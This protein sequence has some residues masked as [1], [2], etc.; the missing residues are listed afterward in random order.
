MSQIFKF[1]T[2]TTPI[3]MYEL[4]D[5]IFVQDPIAVNQVLAYNAVTNTV[6]LTSTFGA[7][8][9]V[10]TFGPTAITTD[11][12]SY[13][14][15]KSVVFTSL[16]GQVIND[17][18][19]NETDNGVPGDQDGDG[20]NDDSLQG[21]T[22]K[23]VISGGAGDDHIAGLGNADI[24]HGGSGDDVLLG[25]AGGDVLDG[26]AG[27][28]GL[29]GDTGNDILDGGSGND[30]L[31]GGDGSDKLFG[32]DGNDDLIGGA[33]GDM[34]DGGAGNDDLYGNLGDDKLIGGAGN[35]SLNGGDGKDALFG[36][37]DDDTLNGNLGNDLL[38]GEDGNDTLNGGDGN[39]QL[40][41]GAGDDLLNGGDGGDKLI[42]SSGN[43]T[44]NG[45]VGNDKLEGGDG[46]DTLLGGD[47]NDQ[48]KGGKG[49][50]TF[51]AGQDAGDDSFSGGSGIDTVDYSAAS[52]GMTINTA[53]GV[54][55][56]TS[57]NS[58]TGT[59]KLDGIDRVIGSNFDDVIIRAGASNWTDGG[60]G[61]DKITGGKGADTLTGGTGN[62]TFFYNTLDDSRPGK[63]D[64][65][66]DFTAGSDKID[67]SAI[68]AIKGSGNDTFTL[69]TSVPTPG[70]GA[71]VVWF[72]VASHTLF[73]SVN[74]DVSAEFAIVLEGVDS[75]S[76]ADLI[77]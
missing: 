73:A 3:T 22:G 57:G 54:A 10:R 31:D 27:N 28:D 19:A 24:L 42:G 41:G 49:D 7:Y 8:I 25:G 69:V 38:K 17:P 77:L 58:G 76:V 67:L 40:N 59:D 60:A 20:S 14:D 52:T 6:T 51:L 9:K 43:D 39:D 37:A 32:G 21:D 18:T 35:D 1:D 11:D 66:T 55:Y 30:I 29:V 34:L 2:T 16:D 72:D 45:N 13:F 36:G 68:D 44:L 62:D 26:G 53:I 75:I 64:H 61:N 56:A 23:N 71:G 65:I 74:S 15:K 50:D 12:V 46:N 63:A 5:G 70:N 33:A 4:H 48:E 47:G